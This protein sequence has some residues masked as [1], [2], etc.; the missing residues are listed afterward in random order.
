MYNTRLKY[1]PKVD[2]LDFINSVLNEVWLASLEKSELAE[3]L[4]FEVKKQ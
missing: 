4:Y 1:F 3:F 2:Q